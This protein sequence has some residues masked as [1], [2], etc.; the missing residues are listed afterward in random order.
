MTWQD[1]IARLT[2]AEFPGDEP[3]CLVV[4]DWSKPAFLQP[5]V[6]EDVKL[7]NEALVAPD[8][9]DLLIT[10]RNHDLKQQIAQSAD[11]D[12][13]VFALVSLQT[14]EGYGGGQG[15]LQGIVRM[16]NAYASRLHISLS[17]LTEK[18]QTTSAFSGDKLKRDICRMLHLRP[19]LNKR[20]PVANDDG[21]G[22]GL[23]W[24]MDWPES[25]PLAI[26]KLDI[27]FIEVCR[28][29]RLSRHG[30]V[31]AALTGG[32]SGKRISPR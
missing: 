4:D 28:R 18:R 1:I 24:I 23:T 30:G 32:S 27:W 25:Q 11:L 14:M 20:F 22:I 15:K 13:W 7:K 6:P 16:S 17:P 2:R 3:W 31:V 5:P 26:S 29:I 21:T 10:S 8:T 12:D 9:L 19:D